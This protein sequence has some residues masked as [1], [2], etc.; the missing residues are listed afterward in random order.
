MRIAP[1]LVVSAVFATAVVTAGLVAPGPQAA[2]DRDGGQGCS[3]RF[4][5]ERAKPKPDGT[6]RIVSW[7]ILNFADREDDPKL[8]GDH[9]DMQ[10][11]ITE[12]RAKKL[13]EVIRELDAD[14]ISFQEGESLEA[15]VWFRD[16]YLADMGYRYV[17][18]IDVG[19]YRGMECSVLSRHR[20]TGERV[21]P[22]ESLD[23]VRR[24]G[25]GWASVPSDKRR[26]LG[27]QRSPLMVDITTDEGYEMTLL[28]LH[29]KSGRD[30]KYHREAE[31]LQTME[32]VEECMKRDPSRNIIVLGDFNAAPWDKSMRVYL[33]GGMIDAHAHRT[34]WREAPETPMYR[35]HE[36]D[37]VLDYILL[38]SAAHRELVLG[39]PFVY[40]GRLS[41][42]ESYNY[43][44]D[45]RP[46]GYASDHYPVVIDIM[47]KD[48]K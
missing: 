43:R 38:N 9:D 23:D 14:I 11:A 42:P 5:L 24:P 28:A 35:T 16:T 7:N 2:R 20:I 45:P 10:Y 30:F 44:T 34:T 21:W 26:G 15:I 13:A 40:G 29:H 27:Y 48:I 18:S 36:S 46:R 8:S 32:I 6:V 25:I 39:S 31:A 3:H 22:R 41:P 4:G 47:P 33:E 37:R 12:E 19:Y 1:P 17:S